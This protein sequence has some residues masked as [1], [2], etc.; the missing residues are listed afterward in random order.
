MAKSSTAELAVDKNGV[1]GSNGGEV[2]VLGCR[3]EMR[4]PST[5]SPERELSGEGR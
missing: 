3:Q 5:V 2:Q 1:C 4:R